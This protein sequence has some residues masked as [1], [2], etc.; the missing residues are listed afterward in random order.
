MNAEVRPMTYWRWVAL[1]ALLALG[2]RVW[3]F[4]Q[5][6]DSDDIGYFH[7]AMGSEAGRVP[8][9]H[10]DLR[11]AFL[12]LIALWRPLL[13]PTLEA[14]YAALYFHALL[15]FLGLALFL[16]VFTT[17]G[18]A[19]TV[20]GLWSVS[21][22]ALTTEVRLLPDVAGLALSLAGV[23]LAAGRPMRGEARESPPALSLLAGG[24]LWAATSVRITFVAWAM[25]GVVV[26]GLSPRW[27]RQL[28]GVVA[29]L[30]LGGMLEWWLLWQIYGDPWIR[31]KV[32]LGYSGL[33]AAAALDSGYHP[34]GVAAM[35]AYFFGHH[36]LDFL[37]R[38][39]L[40]LYRTGSA[41]LPLLLLGGLGGLWWVWQGVSAAERLQRL[42]LLVLPLGLVFF[43]VTGIDPLVAMLREMERY[44]YTALPPLYLAAAAFLVRGWG[45]RGW[46]RQ[47]GA[48]ALL[49]LAGGN[50]QAAW[51][52]PDSVRGG[53]DG[54]L[55]A[56]GAIGQHAAQHPRA[57][58]FYGSSVRV[59]RL[60]LPETAGW[61]HVRNPLTLP[62]AGYLLLDWRRIHHNVRQQGAVQGRLGV[63]SAEADRFMDRHPVLLRRR[64]GLD[65]LDV[66]QVGEE[67]AR[68]ERVP[69]A[70][71]WTGGWPRTLLPGEEGVVAAGTWVFPQDHGAKRLRL[72]VTAH[73]QGGDPPW[74]LAYLEGRTGAGQPG[75]N[76]LGRAAVPRDGG[77]FVLWTDLPPGWVAERLRLLARDGTVVL[78]SAHWSRLA[79]L[80]G[81][82][83][84]AGVTEEGMP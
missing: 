21:H 22:A 14:Y 41:E 84:M 27:R 10:E 29:G 25:T 68:R 16:R 42:T 18:V 48:A 38:Y 40:L 9:R 79:R 83:S 80:P 57:R 24:L 77:T 12:G 46:Q 59:A 67:P 66:L 5:P 49:L 20:L 45:A 2:V 30:I 71:P 32:L 62:E 15:S 34:D 54:A 6:V 76:Y 58:V 73:G 3:L 82:P 50:L 8:P 7:H 35:G 63:F 11:L 81:E 19:L 31:I 44:Y 28:P 17:P 78:E 69:L 39:P 26:A 52:H 37:L 74:V 53:Q 4:H 33:D 1:L 36:L 43:G 61:R 72:E 70:D 47:L 56:Y 55:A 64:Y 60:F 65:L 75:R 23:A 13:G 51:H